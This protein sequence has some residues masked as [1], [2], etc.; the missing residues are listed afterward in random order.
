[1]PRQ[2]EERRLAEVARQQGVDEVRLGDEWPAA[3]LYRLLGELDF[4]VL[5]LGYDQTPRE[6]TVREELRRRGKDT[7][8]VVTL[9][10]FQPDE[11]KS[12]LVHD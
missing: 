3:D 7:V 10:P 9:Q 11:Y 1:E 4:D 12:S 5:A 8:R 6:K 2:S